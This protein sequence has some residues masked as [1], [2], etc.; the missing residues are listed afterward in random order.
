MDNA[1]K[2]SF[3][4]VVEGGNIDKITEYINSGVDINRRYG[5]IGNTALIS[6]CSS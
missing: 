5:K 4:N 3:I 1:K 2:D 6:V